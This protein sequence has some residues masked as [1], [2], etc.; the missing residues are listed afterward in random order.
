MQQPTFWILT[1]V[2]DL[3]NDQVKLKV[4]ALYQARGNST[5]SVGH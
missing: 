5:H 1:A 4:P 3:S 2:D